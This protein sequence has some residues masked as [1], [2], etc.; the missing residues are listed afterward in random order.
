MIARSSLLLPLSLLLAA[1]AP[2]EPPQPKQNKGTGI[3]L[4]FENVR[5]G[6]G[7]LRLCLSRN[8]AHYPDCSKDPQARQINVPANRGS[9]RFDNLPQG[10]YALTALHDENSN[11]KLDTFLGVPR[12]GFAFSNNPRVGFGPPAYER[13]RFSIGPSRALVRLQFKYI[14]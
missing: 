9:F 10:T 4:M 6:R 14:T 7:I 12:E 13:V 8:P 1:A 11:G 2:A 5:S 3:D